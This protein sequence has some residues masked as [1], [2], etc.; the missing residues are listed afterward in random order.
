MSEIK[1]NKKGL[2]SFIIRLIAVAIM[3]AGIIGT[4]QMQLDYEWLDYLSWISFPIFAFLLAVGFEETS[5]RVKY[6]IRLLLF[7]LLAEI[8]YDYLYSGKLFNTSIHNGMLTLCLGYIV[9]VIVDFVSKK[10]NNLILT[11]AVIYITGIGAF[12]LA[13]WLGFE[14]YSFGIMFVLFFYVSRH[15]KYTRLLQLFLVLMLMFYVAS[16]TYIRFIIG[17]IQYSLPFRAY[18]FISLLI[19]WTYNEKRGPNKLW[20]KILMYLYYPLLL[21]VL[22]LVKIFM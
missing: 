7:A 2:N 11:C 3:T 1:E 6:F 13:K 12:E 5:D 15:I 22:C 17:N 18:S 21:G 20:L 4:Q 14:F 8:P 9:L 19:I 10:F 16:N